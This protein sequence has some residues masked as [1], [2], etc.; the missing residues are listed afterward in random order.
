MEQPDAV[1]LALAPPQIQG[2]DAVCVTVTVTTDP[3]LVAAA[4][5]V[6]LAVVGDAVVVGAA[7][8]ELGAITVL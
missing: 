8:H 5:D 1:P 7:V 4:V 6:V 2:A 3:L